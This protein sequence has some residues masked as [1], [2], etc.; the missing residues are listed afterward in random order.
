MRKFALITIASCIIGFLFLKLWDNYSARFEQVEQHYKDSVTFN[1]SKDS[2]ISSEA[3]F[4]ILSYN[5][6]FDEEKDTV[7]RF[8]VKHL[9][10]KLDTNPPLNSLYELNKRAWQIPA[11]VVKESECREFKEKLER[12]NETL[13][14]D[15]A[16]TAWINNSTPETRKSELDLSKGDLMYPRI[17]VN[18][19][20]VM[21][22]GNKEDSIARLD[23]V[24]YHGEGIIAVNVVKR[25]NNA[26][27]IS[28]AIG[29][30]KTPRE[31][32]VVRL[33]EQY[34]ERGETDEP[35][36]HVLCFG[37]TDEDGKVVFK[38]LDETKSYSVLPI[39]EGYEYGAAKGTIRGTLAET[40]DDN[41]LECT[42]NEQEQLVRLFSP[43]TLNQIK[44]DHIFT[45][46]T[47][48]EYK[49][50]LLWYIGA[51]FIAWWMLFIVLALRKTGQYHW[52][53]S[54][55]MLLTGL[56]LL[57][58]F[59]VNDP[60]IDKMIGIDMAQGIITGVIIIALLQFVDFTKFYQN[61]SLIPFDL[62]TNIIKWLFSPF[63]DKVARLTAI[64]TDS[65][66]SGAKK[67]AALA[68]VVICSPLL[69][70]DLL[71]LISNNW[72]AKRMENMPKGTGYLLFALILTAL[73]WTPLGQSVGGMRVNLNMGVLFQ[74]SEIAKYLIVIFMAAFFC[75]NAD[76]IVQYSAKG[77]S[78]LFGR[79]MGMMGWI[80]LGLG[81]LMGLYLILGDM[82]PALVL[83][84]T[85]ILLYSMIKS[86][87]DL[88][89]VA[90]GGKLGKLM[91]CDLAMLLYG[92][93][94]FLG[95]L[96]AG[97]QIDINSIE[98]TAIDPVQPIK[99]MSI[100]CVGWFVLWIIIGLIRKQVWETAIFFNLIIAAFIFGGSLLKGLGVFE[101][102]GDRLDSRM[103]MCTNTWGTLP[104]SG[105]IADPGS[106]TQV[107]E[108]LWG[109]ASG[110][111]N[112]QGLGNGTPHFIPAFHTDMVLESV[113]EQMGFWG[114]LGI[115]ILMAILLRKTIVAGYRT[116][117]P[118]AFYLCLGIAIVTAVQLIIIALGSTGVI[119]L[120]GVT[121]PFFSYGRVSMILNLAAF[122][123]VLS[124][125]R[126]NS[127][128]SDTQETEILKIKRNNIAQYGY[129]VAI[130]SLIYCFI[131]AGIIYVFYNYI[132]VERDNILVKPVY[133]NSNSGMPVIAYNP[134]IAQITDKMEAGDIYDRKGIL[135][136]TSK[137]EKLNDEPSQK[138]YNKY[139]LTCDTTK[140]IKRYYPF[141]KHLYFMLGDFNTKVYFSASENSPRGY[142]AEAR[143]LSELRGYDNI[144]RDANGNPIKVTVESD[145]WAPN[146][147]AAKKYVNALQGQQLRDYTE[148][149]PYLKAG[150]YSNQV[151][152]LTVEE[153]S[154]KGG[155]KP[156]NVQLTIDAELQTKLQNKIAQYIKTNYG[157][158]AWNKV[159]VSSV[160]LD[161]RNG[162]LIASANY[163][164]PDQKLLKE[165]EEQKVY[166]YTDNRKPSSWKAY[167][168][169]DLALTYATAPGSTAKVMS[170]IAGL[171]KLGTSAA[172]RIYPV[173]YS[174]KVGA[175]PAGNISM[176]DAIVK[177]SNC[178]FI[179]MVNE[180]DL[181][182]DMAYIYSNFGVRI[183]T[184]APYWL[185]HDEY[186]PNSS[187]TDSVSS[188]GPKAVTAYRRYLKRNAA[189]A[190]KE[191]MDKSATWQWA[192]GQGTLSAT[193]AAMARVASSVAN[194]GYMPVTRYTLDQTVKSV[195]ILKRDEAETLK[196]LMRDE[197]RL[198]SHFTQPYIGGKTGTA[199]REWRNPQ[200]RVSK[201]NDAWYMCFMEGAKVTRIINGKT[202]IETTPI[203]VVVRMERMGER[204]STEARKLIQNMMLELLREEGIITG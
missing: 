19:S 194:N 109:L 60:L 112:G 163:P 137:R 66:K 138:A 92:V 200:G 119:P 34:V 14:I 181:Y 126:N 108:G 125:V 196:S 90:D 18:D 142:M 124:I 10:A 145:E 9:L 30:D 15:S 113:G 6:Y 159:R 165:L 128:T 177:S 68:G 3:L 131:T 75:I 192:W 38:G 46:R 93:A 127:M 203:A 45:V 180:C 176:H 136:A 102:V 70:F 190:V 171:R 87:V 89:G 170:A 84:F 71:Q 65:R 86:K 83:A 88:N 173:Q 105:N 16:Y 117:H 37:V 172:D 144:K 4:K 154:A 77:N 148:L 20:I 193:P 151:S 28:R 104:V 55:L 167:T 5:N 129:P 120:T 64:M 132:H 134:R 153:I 123:I 52:I 80:I 51:F 27:I 118:F 195:P 74:P 85:F 81:A 23:T 44:D 199:D 143:H 95:C 97:H 79:K 187:W 72:F 99:Y 166:Y 24:P 57:S 63:K 69:I 114:I 31:G 48:K 32:V 96:Y 197:S 47:P 59:S 2:K 56:S 61:Q 53:L 174:Q 158:P 50:E 178:Y 133:V 130:M 186:D 175:E 169:F 13:G 110:G 22:A 35:K 140:R 67:L 179:N 101:S 115:F 36:T 160:I 183:G 184:K 82:G 121:V 111:L 39:K 43:A 201:P 156:Q 155:I 189:L 33:A 146:K 107:A 58:M 157:S 7:S 103:E 42:F 29:S 202:Y 73:L 204:F 139:G 185:N 8:V 198:H 161:A 21:N 191:K 135:L 149:L 41:A 100:F 147:F 11:A 122:G 162:D 1:L 25:D 91:S 49:D 168:D 98:P 40:G 76:K 182:K 78:S 188:E 62:P 106:N 141:G 116:T 164:L 12:L 54:I 26:G 150:L 94:T 152:E 17:N